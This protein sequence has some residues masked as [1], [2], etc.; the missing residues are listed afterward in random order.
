METRINFIRWRVNTCMFVFDKHGSLLIKRHVLSSRN[1]CS[2][3][4]ISNAQKMNHTVKKEI[5]T[6]LLLWKKEEKLDL[7]EWIRFKGH[8]TSSGGSGLC[9]WKPRVLEARRD[10]IACAVD[11]VG[12]SV[13]VVHLV[14]IIA[15]AIVALATFGLLSKHWCRDQGLLRL[16]LLVDSFLLVD[17]VQI[18]RL[19]NQTVILV[20]FKNHAP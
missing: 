1:V 5:L 4:I 16:L 7:R 14:L 18:I 13:D 17:F 20:M 2:N 10:V 11:R 3:P 6:L 19:C 9:H 8:W 12:H 15:Q